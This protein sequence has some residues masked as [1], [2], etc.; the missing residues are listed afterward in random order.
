MWPLKMKMVNYFTAESGTQFI[1]III[2]SIL[3]MQLEI[4]LGPDIPLLNKRNITAMSL[5]HIM[6]L[7]KTLAAHL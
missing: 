1:I 6:M 3:N 7:V 5:N 4:R 2:I